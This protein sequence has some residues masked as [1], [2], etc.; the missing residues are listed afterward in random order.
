MRESSLPAPC[1]S[2][3]M[4]LASTY[5]SSSAVAEFYDCV[6]LYAE[7]G[8]IEFYVAEARASAGLVLE[9]G[10]G[11][12]RILIPAARAGAEVVGLDLSENMLERCRVKL[13][14]ENVS[15]IGRVGL[16]PSSMVNFSLGRKFSLITIPFR[17]FQHLLETSEQLECLDAVARHLSPGGRL[18][19]DCFQVKP[20]AMHHPAWQ[21]E[22]EDSPETLLPDGRTLRRTSRI[23]AFHRERQVNDIEIVWYVTHADGV[24]ERLLW[25]VPLRYF[26]RYEVEH[27]L[28]RAGLQLNAVYGNFDCS[29][30]AADSPEMIFVAERPA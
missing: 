20:E 14:S 2:R 22:K 6:A 8:D 27:L 25:S 23:A 17:S 13:A 26:F 21:D 19:L 4:T 28:A 24:R 10:C 3:S 18:I 1:R 12:G 9:L 5:D 30:L 16:V 15:V 7:R 29:P 11:T